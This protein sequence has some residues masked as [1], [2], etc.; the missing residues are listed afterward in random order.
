MDAHD[1]SLIPPAA[2]HIV[3]GQAVVPRSGGG[4]SGVQLKEDIRI[5]KMRHN[6]NT[7]VPFS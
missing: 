1:K 5:I 3:A 4:S 2:D 6:Q 7:A